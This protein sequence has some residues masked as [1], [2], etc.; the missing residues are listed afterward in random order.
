MA[1]FPEE[2]MAQL[3]S[4]NDIVD[5]VS[6]YVALKPNGGRHWG[7]C[8]FHSEKTPSFNVNADKQFFYCFGC[9]KGGDVVRFIMDMEKLSFPESVEFLARRANMQMPETIDDEQANL[10]RQKRARILAANKAAARFFYAALGG[11]GGRNA[12]AYLKRRGIQ[13]ATIRHFGLG[14]A[15]DSWDA[16]LNHLREKGFSER[17]AMD[18]NLAAVGKSG[19]YDFF[20][21]RLMFPIINP[22]GDVVGFGGRVLDNSLPKYINTSDTTAF[23]K[24]RNLYGLNYLDKGGASCILMVEG[25]MDVVSLYQRGGVHAV[26][27]LGTALT[28]EQARLMKRYAPCVYVAYDGDAAGQRATLRGLDILR[29]E[30]LEV[31]VVVFPQ[32]LD[33]DEF[34]SREGKA[35]FENALEG[36]LPL[37]EYKLLSLQKDF[38]MK[39]AEQ[40]MKYAI[41]AA[42]LLKPLQDP[43]EKERYL[44]L[45]RKQTGFTLEALQAQAGFAVETDNK[46]NRIG[47]IR[48]NKPRRELPSGYVKAERHILSTMAKGPEALEHVLEQGICFAREDHKKLAEAIA[49]FRGKQFSYADVLA[50]LDEEKASFAAE[51]FERFPE[52]TDQRFFQDC[53]GQVKLFSLEEEIRKLQEMA[54]EQVQ[55]EE[56][57][58][59]LQEIQRLN[60]E[61]TQLRKALIG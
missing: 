5:V 15:P 57:D 4:N 20:R 39:D 51:V 38:D 54:A 9:H 43:V 18:A 12:R 56:K 61:Y 48:D 19:A 31:R 58:R 27:T 7:L 35:A 33:P 32:G 59:L 53:V 36:A 14:F 50:A 44:L 22:Y 21:N 11:G 40:R 2:W 49:G 24:R 41:A 6:Q 16:L 46:K 30:G 55:Q 10:M 17:E 45:L 3:R 29:D 23:N 1:G 42:G 26:A 34:I 25:Y 28:T 13:E 37:M 47:K 60:L 52:C 8:P